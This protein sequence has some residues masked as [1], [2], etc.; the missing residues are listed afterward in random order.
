MK[1]NIE[2]Y[3]DD[4]PE[5]F[6]KTIEKKVVEVLSSNDNID[7]VEV[8]CSEIDGDKLNINIAIKPKA[9]LEKVDVTFD[10]PEGMSDE[11][12]EIFIKHLQKAIEEQ[13]IHEGELTS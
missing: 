12:F 9:S 13:N 8:K 1:D 3:I 4:K 6:T 5:D 2:E 7:E 11:Q 10:K